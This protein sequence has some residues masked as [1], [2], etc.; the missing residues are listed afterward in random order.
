VAALTE[1]RQSETRRYRSLYDVDIAD[2]ANYDLVIV[3]DD[4]AVAD[5]AALVLAAA[6]RGVSQKF[7]LP[8]TR[9]VPLTPWRDDLA[10]ATAAEAEAAAPLPLTVVHNWG[11]Y[12]GPPEPLTAALAT[13]RPFLAYVPQ[14]APDAEGVLAE[15]TR[16]ATPGALARWGGLGRTRLAFANLL[17]PARP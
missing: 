9:L 10:P 13:D 8:K 6:R 4:A 5:V 15:A 7:W 3:T 12:A 16:R 1:R 14:A 17:G 2:L 11:F